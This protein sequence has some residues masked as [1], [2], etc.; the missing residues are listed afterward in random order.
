MV[1]TAKTGQK[2]D[3]TSM[4]LGFEWPEIEVFKLKLRDGIPKDNHCIL[5]YPLR[6]TRLCKAKETS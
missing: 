5:G 4:K 6:Q 3:F 1:E 2:L